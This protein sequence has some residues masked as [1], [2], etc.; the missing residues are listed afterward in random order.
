MTSTSYTKQKS[1]S[2]EYTFKNKIVEVDSH[3][4]FSVTDRNIRE[5][6]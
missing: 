3:T 5:M 4:S 6:L 2:K 1:K